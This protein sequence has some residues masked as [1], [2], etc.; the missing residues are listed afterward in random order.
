MSARGDLEVRRAAWEDL[1][2]LAEI[3]REAFTDPWSAAVLAAELQH[4]CARLWLGGSPG[5]PPAGYAAFRWTGPEG[6]LLR[7]ATVP[8]ERRRGLASALLER[9][10]AFLTAQ[11]AEVCH[12]E[13]RADNVPAIALY[14]RFGFRTVGRRTGYYPGGIDALLMT[15]PL[16]AASGV[17]LDLAIDH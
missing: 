7:L 4:P 15:A 5:A 1:P 2:L 10:L 3:E 14:E 13:V 6:E 8:G 12:L 11:E 16:F 17:D 9:G